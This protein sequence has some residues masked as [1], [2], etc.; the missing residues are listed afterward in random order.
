MGIAS[1]VKRRE[2]NGGCNNS[3]TVRAR[4]R[5]SR[6]TDDG[7]EIG[8]E[9]GFMRRMSA[10][11]ELGGVHNGFFGESHRAKILSGRGLSQGDQ[12]PVVSEADLQE[13]GA[14][15]VAFTGRLTYSTGLRLPGI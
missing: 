12:L 10:S 3:G 14:P 7:G 15:H 6:R 9:T 2:G 1:L 5:L 13:Y 11:N 4:R 8:A